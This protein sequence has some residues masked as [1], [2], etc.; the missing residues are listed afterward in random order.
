MS[1]MT[2][3]EK[4]IGRYRIICRLGA[5]GMGEVFLAEDSTLKRRVA[6]KILPRASDGDEASRL[7]LLREAQAA[8][9]LDHP[10][11]CAVYEVGEDGGRS[12]I[13]MQFV[14][15]ETLADRLAR[16]PIA[17]HAA[18]RIAEA[19]ADALGAAHA[20]GIVH[21]D[22]KPANVMLSS[23]GQIKVVDFGLAKVVGPSPT[24]SVDE[25][26]PAITAAGA[27]VGTVAYMSPEQVRGEALDTRTDV[28][29]L[30]V[31]LHEM[32]SGRHPFR[33]ASAAESIAAVLVETS[34]ALQTGVEW[35]RIVGKCL[36][37]ERERRYV[38]AIDLLVDLRNLERETSSSPVAPARAWRPTA[39]WAGLSAAAAIAAIVVS[40]WSVGRRPTPPDT[41]PLRVLAI[42]PLQDSSANG[43]GDGISESVINSLSQLSEL[44]VLGRTTTFRYRG[45]DIDL[46]ALRG[47]DPL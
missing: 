20:R 6:V 1:E 31:V 15:G 40:I 7:R 2:G 47:L 42:L 19:I 34:P 46:A 38:S 30:G 9:T 27:I 26:A 4:T 3:L 37:K 17:P 29:S 21:R 43:F 36:A 33:R 44:K 16:G 10:N 5:G 14:D 18:L 45:A 13:A 25:T 28:F 12:F 24:S 11:V 22:V 32:L 35:Q 8:A 23:N 41:P 39:R